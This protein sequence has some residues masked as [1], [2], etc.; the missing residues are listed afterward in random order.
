MGM[1][2]VNVSTTLDAASAARDVGEVIAAIGEKNKTVRH[3]RWRAAGV[4]Q[5]MHQPLDRVR[6]NALRHA[7][8]LSPPGTS[9]HKTHQMAEEMLGTLLAEAMTISDELY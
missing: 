5:N 3:T 9:A 4:Q 6:S 7:S 8:R 2:S 1:S